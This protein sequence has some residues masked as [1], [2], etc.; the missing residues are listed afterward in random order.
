MATLSRCEVPE[1]VCRENPEAHDS[2]SDKK[3]GG[4]LRPLKRA[5]IGIA[6]VGSIGF[7]YWAIVRPAVDARRLAT[8]REHLGQIGR[9]F[10]AYHEAQG[11]FPTPAILGR[12]GRPLLSWRVALLPHLG[13][14]SL[15]RRFHLDE[16][17]DSPHNLAL[18]EEMPLIFAC[19]AAD[20]TGLPGRTGYRVV[21]GP[22]SELGSV[23]TM[24]EPSRGVDLRQVLDGT[25]LTLMVGETHEVVPWTKPDDLS[26]PEGAGVPRFGSGHPGGFHALLADSSVRFFKSTVATTILRSLLTINGGEVVSS[27]S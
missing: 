15:Y 18:I 22:K 11:T 21:V 26:L 3:P 4:R 8:C 10:H 17:W 24:F 7:V 23:N 5:A 9:A 12:D 19:P 1:S 2:H 25:S 14:D 13:Y 6:L 27:D 20:A 16:P